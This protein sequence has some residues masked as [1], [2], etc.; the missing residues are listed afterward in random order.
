MSRKTYAVDWD[1]TLVEYQGYIGP[2][3]FGPPV[4][5]MVERVKSWLMTG[6]E[7]IIYTARVSEEW[8]LQEVWNEKSAIRD[9]LYDMGLPSTLQITA[10]KFSRV[11]EFWDDR[12]VGVERNTGNV[13]H[14]D[15]GTL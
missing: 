12:A 4:P 8:N 14:E 6:H 13:R 10:N 11:T 3:V 9:A 15:L 1:G 2:G 7:V 5:A